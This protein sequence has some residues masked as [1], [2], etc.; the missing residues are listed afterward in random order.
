MLARDASYFVE[1]EA[2]TSIGKTRSKKAYDLLI[3][4]LAKD[5]FN[6]VIRRAAMSGLA[7]LGDERAIPVLLRWTEYG[8]PPYAREAAIATLGKLGQGKREV[9]NRIVDLLDDKNFYARLAAV[10]ALEAL[11]DAEAIPTLQRLASQDIEGR[12]KGAAA[13]AVRAITARLEKPAEIKQLRGE[14]ETLRESNKTLLD[15][16]ER[17]EAKSKVKTRR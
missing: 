10:D 5:S 15:R 9:R 12:L 14:I 4:A 3:K 1:A 16:L 2:A 13:N 6:E 7:E 17:L 11:Q 8:K